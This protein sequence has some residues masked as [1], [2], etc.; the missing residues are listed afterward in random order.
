MKLYI[1][2]NVLIDLLCERTPFYKESLKIFSLANA[3]KIE[4]ITSS[5]NIVNTHY[6]LNDIMKIGIIDKKEADF[7]WY[8]PSGQKGGC[9]FNLDLMFR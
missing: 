1:D 2:I 3:N 6:I 7:G 5:L 4:L 8:I 9:I